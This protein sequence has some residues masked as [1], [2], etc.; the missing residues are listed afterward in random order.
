MQV[1][2]HL[3]HSNWHDELK[4]WRMEHPAG[5][6]CD[7]L[8]RY[9][10][11][12]DLVRGM[13]LGAFRFSLEW[14]RIEPEPGR[15]DDEALAHYQ[16]IIDACHARGIE[17]IL[18]LWHFSY[19]RWIDRELPGGWTNP[20]IVEIFGR[21]AR[22]AGERLRGVKWWITQNEPN[23]FVLNTWLFA[24]YP[25]APAPLLQAGRCPAVAANVVAAH[26]VAY[27]ILKAQDRS[28]MISA[29]VFHFQPRGLG[30]PN[31]LEFF[32]RLESFD[33]I[34]IDYYFAHLPWEW[35]Y[36]AFQWAWPVHPPGIADSVLA[37]WR[38]FRKPVLIGE[39]GLCQHGDR[40]RRDGWTRD[41]YLV[42][43][44]HHLERAAQAGADLVG[45]MHW[46]LLD[47]WEFGSYTPRFG[48]YQVD[49]TRP[50]L[51]R[52]PTAAVEAYQE[53]AGE[54]YAAA[55]LLARFGVRR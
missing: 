2:G 28:R 32:A 6:G 50:D 55:P 4:H 18:T 22:K 45:Y 43:H 15:F 53:I 29:N 36:L 27:D 47:N 40:P 35:P 7:F 39:N 44:V 13:G 41:R 49:F 19:P 9:E 23:A 3:Q 8:N 1:E 16:R 46:S 48:L 21:F 34:S 20:E 30:W 12:L 54:G 52:T 33:Y 37:Y 38:R 17:P 10:S 26:Q 25:P 42:H 51:P 11:D 5:R 14:G 31:T 24:A